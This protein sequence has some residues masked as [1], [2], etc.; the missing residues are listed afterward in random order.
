MSRRT[1]TGLVYIGTSV[2][3]MIAR[4]DG[5]LD[6]LTSRG[7]AAGDAGYGEFSAQIDTMLIGRS[8]YD[9]V[10]SFGGWP[11]DGKRVLVL[12]TTLERDV[13]ERI[14]IVRDL[15]EA[16]TV[17]GD[18]GA[19]NV[20]ID[21]GRTIQTCLEAGLVDE[22]TI[23]AVPVLLGDGVRLFGP[24][25]AEIDLT[26]ISTVVLGGGMVQTR[27]AVRPGSEAERTPS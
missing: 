5:S 4:A 1:W 17:L 2:D 25:S 24:L 13:D 6:W 19:R 20:Y 16:T 9:V 23:S 18:I 12:T 26:H 27:Y 14:M 8:T 21:G 22:L 11:Y 3:G 7:E 15:D 10:L